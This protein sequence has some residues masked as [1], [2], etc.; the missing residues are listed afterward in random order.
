MF[1]RGTHR[2]LAL[3][4]ISLR[5]IYVLDLLLR[6]VVF[7]V[8]YE[9]MKL[10]ALKRATLGVLLSLAT[11]PAFA[12]ACENTRPHWNAAD[13]N[14]TMLGETLHILTGSGAIGLLIVMILAARFQNFWFTCVICACA[15]GAAFLYYNA[16]SAA[17]P[18]STMAASIAEGCVGPPYGGITILILAA[19]LLITWQFFGPKRQQS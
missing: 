3:S 11:T 2:A 10:D 12:F 19:L 5:E 14:M 16:W 17:D 1:P 13:G 9:A 7:R 4:N 6:P 18:K 15:F 8:G